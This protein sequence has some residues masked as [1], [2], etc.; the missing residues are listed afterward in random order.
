MIHNLLPVV[1]SEL[2]DYFK[3]RYGVREDRLI[4]SNLIDQDGSI[5]LEG[6]NTVVCSL[7]NVEEETTLKATA[8][9]TSSGGA[10]VKSS[11]DIYVNLTVMFSSYFVGKNYVEALKFLSGVIYFFQGKPVFTNDNTPGLTDNVEKAVFD[12]TSLSF[13]DLSAIFQMM[14]SKYLPSVV[15]RIRMLTFSTDNMEDTVPSISGIG[16]APEGD[17]DV[18]GGTEGTDG[19]S[20]AED[21]FNSGRRRTGK[22]KENLMA[23]DLGDID[24]E[25]DPFEQARNRAQEAEERAMNQDSAEEDDSSEQSRN[26]KTPPTPSLKNSDDDKDKE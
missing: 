26:R 11:P 22:A 15:Y 20:A 12:L 16:I 19:D 23:D 9:T 10:F 14:G 8:G 7:V 18:S 13:H 25:N 6:S 1:C 2:N 5:A 3:S 24:S 17:D 4:L 21:A